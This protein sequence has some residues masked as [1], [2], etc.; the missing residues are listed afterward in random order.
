MSINYSSKKINIIQTLVLSFLL[1][2][3]FVATTSC[4]SGDKTIVDQFGQLKVSGNKILDQN[5]SQIALTGMSLFWSQIKGKYYNY[6]CVKWLRDDWKCTVVRAAMGIEN[7]DGL[8]GYLV[9]KETEFNKVI[10][11]I[12]AAIDLGIYV[13]ID[14]HDH[15]AHENQEE[16]VE[17]FTKIA[18]RYG[19]KPNIIYEIYNEPMQI[20]WEDDVKPY[21][22]ELVKTIRSI[23]PDNLIIIG[24]TTWSQDV[25]IASENPIVGSNLVYSLH[26]YASSHKQH[27]RDKAK[28]AMDNG[29]ALFVS[30]YGTTEYTGDGVIDTV[31]VKAW[32]DFMESNKISWCN[33]SIGDKAEASAAL[34]PGADANGGWTDKD[35]SY[36]GHMVRN[37]IISN[38]SKFFINRSN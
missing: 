20:S 17:F 38:N 1:I 13:I 31:E 27:L 35:I 19:D 14:W 34:I 28:K 7:A 26:F 29:V 21:S 23:D 11:V 12:E 6:D 36:S 8:D 30:E 5:G 16:A 22:I 15:H 18:T 33:W 10:T 2:T 3:I 37:R 32:F 9:N 4:E 25:D 24:T